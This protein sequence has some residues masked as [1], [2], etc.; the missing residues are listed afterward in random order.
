MKKLHLSSL[1]I[2]TVATVVR[3][4]SP[5]P[6]PPLSQADA[7]WAVVEKSFTP[8]TANAGAPRPPQD[9]KAELIQWGLRYYRGIL[10]AGAE[11]Y[12]KYPED[13]R[14]W[15]AVMQMLDKSGWMT[16]GI[17][18]DAAK[19]A[20]DT[21]ISA[22]DRV[23]WKEKL[24]KLRL[25]GLDAKD[26]PARARVYFDSRTFS[27]VRNAA[28]KALREKRPADI[29]AVKAEFDR[30][31]AKYPDQP[32]IGSYANGY[33]QLKEEAGATPDEI[34]QEWQMLARSA[35]EAVRK[36]AEDRLRFLDLTSRPLDMVFTAADGRA[37]DL[38]RLR[39]KVVLVDFWATWCGPCKEE[40]PNVKKVYAAYHDRGFEVVG[41]SLENGKLTPQDTPEQTAA[42]LAAAKK[43]LTDFTVKEEMPWPQYFD[44]KYW[45]NDISTKYSINGI[46]AMF[47]LDQDG[48]VV[49]TNARGEL[50]EREVK[51]L[52]KL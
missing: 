8:A 29:A 2:L 13:P 42:K 46:P 25:A 35:S 37:V 14:R 20:A 12:E 31:A 17:E 34:K 16:D 1:F 21:V 23:R 28:G 52:L 7:D 3:A 11:F 10:T 4:Q 18:T 32:S 26:T 40:I 5:M 15:T 50:L 36:V 24:E 39:G 9:Q 22:S 38:G 41:I 30:L 44:G 6:P 19:Q 33:V 43:I 47:L 49:S 48:K 45:K 51:R 27:Q